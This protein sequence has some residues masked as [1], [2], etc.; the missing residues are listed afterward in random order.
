MKRHMFSVIVCLLALGFLST[1]AQAQEEGKWFDLSNFDPFGHALNN[2]EECVPGLW[3]KGVIWN[4]TGLFLNGRGRE[5]GG[6]TMRGNPNPP[7]AGRYNSNPGLPAGAL[8]KRNYNLEKIEWFTEL[9]AR[10]VPPSISNLEF[11]SIWDFRYNAL[12]DWDHSFK[13]S[14]G[15]TRSAAR[16]NLYP[17]VKEADEYYNDTKRIWRELYLKWTPPGWIIQLG[18]QQHIWAKVDTKVHDSVF[19]V[20]LRYGTAANPRLTQ[21]DFEYVNL[22]TWMLSVTRQF[23]PNLYFQLIWNFDYERNYYYPAGYVWPQGSPSDI[24]INPAAL[25]TRMRADMPTW[26]VK[27]HEWITRLGFNYGGWNGH[28]FYAYYWDKS[29]TGFRR[30]FRIVGGA[31]RYFVEPKPTRLHTMGLALDKSFWFL[32]RNW[33]MFF[34]NALDLNKYL[35]NLNESVIALGLTNPLLNKY[36]GYSKRSLYRQIWGVESYFRQDFSFMLYWSFTYLFGRD[37]GIPVPQPASPANNISAIYLPALTWRAPFTEDRWSITWINMITPFNR[38]TSQNTF[39]TGYTFSNY[40]TAS[41]LFHYFY[42]HPNDLAW[43]PL[44]DRNYV[45]FKVK[46]EF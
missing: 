39:G 3:L 20:D 4:D 9:E 45:E 35:P 29:M 19:P 21:T 31:P 37:G 24:G 32:N 14:F 33:G 23:T 18:K 42:G 12:Y 6:K 22:P 13:H 41:V 15:G 27:D 1:L 38:M 46:Y 2:V 8:R 34:E 11:V 10:Y 17:A 43:G 40:L 16:R 44:N 5:G 28:L 30:A 26:N 25:T 7:A 36:D